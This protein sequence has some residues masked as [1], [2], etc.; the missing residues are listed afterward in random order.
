M[1]FAPLGTTV[2]L[3]CRHNHQLILQFPQDRLIL[4]RIDPK[5]VNLSRTDILAEIKG[6][7]IFPPLS[8]E[9]RQE[10]QIIGS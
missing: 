2:G 8:D 1:R 6:I 10:L 3:S 5:I 7:W 4:D 9:L